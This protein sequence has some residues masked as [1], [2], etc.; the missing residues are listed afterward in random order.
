MNISDVRPYKR[1]IRIKRDA[2]YFDEITMTNEF[3]RGR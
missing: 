3:T 2:E 1:G